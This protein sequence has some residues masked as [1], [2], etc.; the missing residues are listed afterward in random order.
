MNITWINKNSAKKLILFFNGWGMDKNI[1]QHI[2]PLGYDIC[3][4]NNYTD[5]KYFDNNYDSYDK[6]YVI[7]WSLGVW[8][9]ERIINNVEIK[10]EK[11]IAI[12]GTSL[13]IDNMY[14]IP[15][16][17]FEGTANNWNDKNKQKFWLRMFS[18]KTCLNDFSD[19]L[20]KRESADQ[21]NEILY[22]TD[23]ILKHESITT[24]NWD[25]AICGEKDQIFT[26]KNQKQFW[27][28]KAKTKLLITN[29]PHFPFTQTETWDDIINEKF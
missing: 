26:I 23:K 19:C 7:A 25:T 6:I 21:K 16:N 5:I 1:V 9:A 22:L 3:M 12:N 27:V 17:I 2:K 11:S 29:I 18:G 28:Q 13:P 20:P 10:I 15:K 4:F 14:G 24:F 8:A